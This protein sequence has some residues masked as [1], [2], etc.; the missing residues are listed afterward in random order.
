MMVITVPIDNFFVFLNFLVNYYYSYFG[1]FNQ[2]ELD[3]FYLTVLGKYRYIR[4]CLNLAVQQHH[5]YFVMDRRRKEC[6]SSWYLPLAAKNRE[7][8]KKKA[9]EHDE[10][11]RIYR[12]HRKSL[13]V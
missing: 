1:E 8:D 10:F 2:A 13:Y 12:V 3:Y 11:Y 6:L 5:R 4:E 9:T 7:Y